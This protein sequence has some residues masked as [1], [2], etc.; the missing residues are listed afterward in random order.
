V[1]VGEGE[2]SVNSLKK[3]SISQE[4][5]LSLLS[6]VMGRVADEDI[7]FDIKSFNRKQTR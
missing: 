1:F 2:S 6:F 3:F 4:L 5:E 7:L